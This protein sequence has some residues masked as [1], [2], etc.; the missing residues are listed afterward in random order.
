MV[1]DTISKTMYRREYAAF[2]SRFQSFWKLT[3]HQRKNVVYR[4]AP[5]HSTVETVIFYRATVCNAT[6]S[7]AVVILPSV[8]PSECQTLN[9]ALR[10]FSYH[11][12]RQSLQFSDTNNGWW[13]MP[14]SFWNLRSKL[15]TPFEKRLLRPISA[16]NVSTVGDS[17][18]KFN[19][20]DE[21]KV[22]HLLSNEL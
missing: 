2:R 21:Y 12:K 14:P 20:Y 6:H 19:Y 16:H 1:N 3:L 8:C 9:D 4:A 13:A 18:N 10:I 15:P 5:R 7:I 11:T 22:D 17:E